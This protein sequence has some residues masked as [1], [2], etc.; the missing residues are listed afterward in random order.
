[1]FKLITTT[2]LLI[3]RPCASHLLWRP[4]TTVATLP[5]RRH[6]RRRPTP[7][8]SASNSQTKG[9]KWCLGLCEYEGMDLTGVGVMV[10]LVHGVRQIRGGDGRCR[11]ISIDEASCDQS[12]P[13]AWPPG[14]REHPAEPGGYGGD[15]TLVPIAVAPPLFV[16][17]GMSMNWGLRRSCF[18]TGWMRRQGEGRPVLIRMGQAR[19]WHGPWRWRQVMRFSRAACRV[20]CGWK[21]FWRGGPIS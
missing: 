6:G 1:M 21:G 20:Y 15:R 3:Y 11:A 16:L 13:W 14:P 12:H 17:V 5:R 4:A 2:Q 10:E 7:C 8:L 19:G 18:G 9:A